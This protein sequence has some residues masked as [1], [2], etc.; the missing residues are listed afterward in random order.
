MPTVSILTPIY[1]GLE[2]LDECGQSVFAQTYQDWEWIL[3]ING[4]GPDGGEVYPHA[5]K[6]ANKDP[7]VRVLVQGPPL[8]GK[9]ASLNDAMQHIQGE[10]VC[11]LDCDDVWLPE[12][13]ERQLAVS[14]GIARGA[15]VIGTGCQYI[16]ER[17]TIPALQYGWLTFEDMIQCNHIVNSSCLVHRSWCVW[18]DVFADDCDMW[19]RIGLFGGRMYNIDEILV[20]HRIHTTSAF[21]SKHISPD[22]LR[23]VFRTAHTI[24]KTALTD[25]S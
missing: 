21:N 10:W 11:V 13:L 24:L 1:N 22:T 15:A 9:V 2:F 23:G 17:R 6:W 7:R 14:Q 4:H 3:A 25:K 8:K 5:M 16:G 20:Y 19:L 18:R 12:K